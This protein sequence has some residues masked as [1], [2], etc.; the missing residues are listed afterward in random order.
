[1]KKPRRKRL[2]IIALVVIVVAGGS[3]AARFYLNREKPLSVLVAP[4]ERMPLLVSKVNGSG[5]IRTK[6][7]VDVQAEIAGVIVELG[8]R[9]GDRVRKDQILLRIDPFQ[10]DADVQAARAQ[11]SALEAE[12][13]GHTFQIASSEANA[14]RDEFLKKTAEVEVRQTE[15]SLARAQ[16]AYNRDKKLLEEKLISADQFEIT[17]TQLKLNRAYVEA[18]ASKVSQYEAQIKAARANL[19]Y[20]RSAREATIQR[21]EAARSALRRS[22][23]LLKKT[24]I[25]SM[26][27]GVVVKLN[28]EVGERAVPGTLHNP[29]ATLMVIADFS[30]IEAELKID[31]T[32]IVHIEMDDTAT[33]TV[34]ALPDLPLEGK[35]VEIG[36]S[37]INAISSSSSMSSGG[38]NQEG[39]DFKVVV[40]LTNPPTSLR[41]G[42]SCEAD[43]TTSIKRDVPVVP[44]QALTLREVRLD[45]SGR[46]QPPA[47]DEKRGGAGTGVLSASAAAPENPRGRIKEMQGVFLCGSEGRAHFR[48]VKTGSTGETDIE[49][50]EGLEV[51]EEVIVGPL[52]ALRTLEEHS[53]VVIDRTKPFKR[54]RIDRGGIEEGE[55][56]K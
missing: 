5:E 55:V 28:V 21:V 20:A 17:E 46:Y 2:L 42:M 43:I 45:E 1:M 13:A 4:V 53:R 39:K 25:R 37:P 35:V 23:D 27:D 54:S 56:N 34:D 10:T 6:E 24:T 51:G 31:E 33:V 32:D 41:P 48:L 38:S 3:T 52:K 50:V 30:T 36:N 26:L 44:L 15:T 11:L 8:V 22:E 19:D 29:Q 7:S 18:A 9:E 12:A 47:V 14:A 16:E 40:R 49:V